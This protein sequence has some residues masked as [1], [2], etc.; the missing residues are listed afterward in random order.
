MATLQEKQ[1]MLFAGLCQQRR[2]FPQE[3]KNKA[4]LLS[5][6]SLTQSSVCSIQQ[7]VKTTHLP[8]GKCFYYKINT[9]TLLMLSNPDHQHR[10]QT[11]S[12]LLF[13]LK[14]RMEK[15]LGAC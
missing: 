1:S 2:L 4:G 7:S 5:N 3:Q 13:A 10:L 8:I 12:L 9:A 11:A 6:Q 14:T 15:G